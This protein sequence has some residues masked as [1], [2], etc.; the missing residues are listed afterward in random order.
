M[1]HPVT[2]TTGHNRHHEQ[3][4]WKGDFLTSPSCGL[5][6]RH[7]SPTTLSTTHKHIHCTQN[8]LQEPAPHCFCMISSRKVLGTKFG[9]PR[10]I[11]QS[12]YQSPF[13]LRHCRTIP[14]P[15]FFC[16][17]FFLLKMSSL[18]IYKLWAYPCPTKSGK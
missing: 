11:Q 9:I 15:V 13:M 1:L 4:C 12:D 7:D 8:R 14:F 6:K 5:Q 17:V 10:S 16:G 2:V 18:N 3:S